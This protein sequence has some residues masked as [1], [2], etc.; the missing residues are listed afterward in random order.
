MQLQDVEISFTGDITEQE[1]IARCLRHLILTPEGTYPMSRDFGISN[2]ALALPLPAAHNIIAVDIVD[3]VTK[4][5][6]RV[7]VCEVSFKALSNTD[8]I[9]GKFI[10]K[11]VCTIG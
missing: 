10:A 7:S 5:E 6:P 9:D 4:Y 1:D 11:V 3:K 8:A 2:D